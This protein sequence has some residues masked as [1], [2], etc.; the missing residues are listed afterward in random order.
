MPSQ[1][2]L[3]EVSRNSI[4]TLIGRLAHAHWN[5]HRFSWRIRLG[6]TWNGTGTGQKVWL[7]P[8][9]SG[10][11]FSAMLSTLRRCYA[12]S[13]SSPVPLYCNVCS[14]LEEESLINYFNNTI[15]NRKKYEG[16][17]WDDVIHR[18]KETE[19]VGYAHK[20]P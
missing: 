13:S 7:E 3:Q 10:S 15:F 19:L 8:T 9:G 17:H 2:C 1:R 16:E 6:G 20:V 5:S 14:S 12:S 18:Y 11:G 4:G